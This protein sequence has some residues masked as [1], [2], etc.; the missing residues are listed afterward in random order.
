MGLFFSEIDL[1]LNVR[2]SSF[3]GMTWEV[4][5][6]FQLYQRIVNFGRRGYKV[7]PNDIY[8]G[9][10]IADRIFDLYNMADIRK[11]RFQHLM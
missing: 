3:N 10:S 7:I 6:E 11:R 5:M 9:Y 8:L 1:R 4:R 2:A